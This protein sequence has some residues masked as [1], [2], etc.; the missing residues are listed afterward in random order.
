M[1]PPASTI[2]PNPWRRGL[3]AVTLLVLGLLLV[4]CGGGGNLGSTSQPNPKG[5]TPP[6][7]LLQQLTGIPPD[8]LKPFKDA[9]AQSAG[10]HDIGI[11]EGSGGPGAYSLSGTF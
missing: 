7:V 4:A 9:L 3:Q 8:K 5:K 10:Q 11:V 6:P 1:P 2:A